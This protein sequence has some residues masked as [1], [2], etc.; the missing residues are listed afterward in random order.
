VVVTVNRT[1]YTQLTYAKTGPRVEGVLFT[2]LGEGDL[3]DAQF[4]VSRQEAPDVVRM[5]ADAFDY[6]LDLDELPWDDE[7]ES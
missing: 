3:D 5:L 1:M 2:Q 4:Y 6:E 7:D